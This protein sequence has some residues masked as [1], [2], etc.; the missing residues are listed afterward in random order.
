VAWTSRVF[1]LAPEPAEGVLG[2]LDGVAPRGL[3]VGTGGSLHTD[4]LHQCCG[5]LL[6]GAAIRLG[7]KGMPV[8][9]GNHEQ[10]VQLGGGFL[11]LQGPT[12]PLPGGIPPIEADRI[13]GGEGVGHWTGCASAVH[14]GAMASRSPD[15]S[16]PIR[17]LHVLGALLGQVSRVERLSS[18][19]NGVASRRLRQ[20]MATAQRLLDPLPAPLRGRDWGE[21]VLWSALRWG[22]AGLLLAL[23]LH[24]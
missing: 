20:R 1:P 9:V 4:Q 21:G 23:W 10:A 14:P 5:Q 18:D 8:T 19:D 15:P 12:S 22:G 3:P 6:C 24:R 17:W 7:F 16:P 13:G 2:Q 11:A